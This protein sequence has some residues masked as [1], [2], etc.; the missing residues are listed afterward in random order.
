MLG[1][2]L[3]AVVGFAHRLIDLLGEANIWHAEK[4]PKIAS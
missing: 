2:L 1:L 3:E 4:Y